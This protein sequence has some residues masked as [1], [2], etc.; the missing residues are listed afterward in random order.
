M[1]T[2]ERAR[3]LFA[4][5]PTIG[6]LTNRIDR[7]STSLTGNVA[8]TLEKNGRMRVAVGAN[9]YLV[10]RVIWLYMTGA[11]P[12]NVID[13]IDGNPA[14]NV[15]GNLRDVPLSINAQNQKNH[16]E[17][18]KVGFAGVDAHRGRW[19]AQ[20]RVNYT[21]K[22]IGM[23]DTPEEAH[24]AYIDAKRKYHPGCVI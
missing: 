1:L 3:E 22:H 5:E 7:C 15:W 10:H 4:Y 20:I 14:N 21:K 23:F 12:S 24:Q 9:K 18:N 16:H 13:H 8:G 11:W 17:N 2:P 6:I 19:R